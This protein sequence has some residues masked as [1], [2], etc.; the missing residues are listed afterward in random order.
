MK[1]HYKCMDNGQWGIKNLQV[2]I[3]HDWIILCLLNYI[4][5][6]F[7]ATKKYACEKNKN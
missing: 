5:E 2:K 1:I 3:M 6:L 7:D 4:C